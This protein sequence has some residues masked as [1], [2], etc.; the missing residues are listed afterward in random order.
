MKNTFLF[1]SDLKWVSESH[2]R[3]SHV[4]KINIKLQPG[5]GYLNLA[6]TF[7]VMTEQLQVT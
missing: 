7:E 5:E 4:F 3:Y 6:W 1:V 2:L